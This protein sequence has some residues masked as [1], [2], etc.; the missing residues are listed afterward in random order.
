M[1]GVNED[2]NAD[3]AVE[4]GIPA[5]PNSPA[6]SPNDP[7]TVVPPIPMGPETP[8]DLPDQEGLDLPKTG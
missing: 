7:S 8:L 4:G 2:S 3:E 1:S 5:A 6:G